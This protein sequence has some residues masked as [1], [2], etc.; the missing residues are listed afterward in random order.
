M[1]SRAPAVEGL[2]VS[3]FVS[4]GTLV[5][6]GEAPQP[7]VVVPQ[8]VVESSISNQIRDPHPEKRE[9]KGHAL[10]DFSLA[11]ETCGAGR[12]SAIFQ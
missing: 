7:L 4:R 12:A 1:R 10:R 2:E 5:D 11:P 8:L 6:A 9:M 3:G